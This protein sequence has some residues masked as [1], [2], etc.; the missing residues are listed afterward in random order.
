M[1]ILAD[2]L[3]SRNDIVSLLV[4]LAV[5]LGLARI[6]GEL[7]R[8]FRQ[9][10]VIGEILAGI[11]LGPSCLAHFFP[12]MFTWVF[13]DAGPTRLALEGMVTLGVLLL[14][15]VAG[16]EVDLS[17]ALRQGK[18]AMMVSFMGIVVPF[19]IGLTGAWF[20]GRYL[21]STAATPADH[22]SFALFMGIALSITALPVISKILMDLNMLRSDIGMLII[23]AAMIDDLV[24]WIGFA[25]V[26]ATLSQG[27]NA[28]VMT[29][30][31]LTLAYL[32]L[33]LTLGRLLIHRMIP[34][35]QART[36]WPGGVIGFILVVTLFAAAFTEWIGVHAIFGAFIAGVAIGDSSHLRQR[37]RDTIHQFI[38][39]FFAPIFFAT[40][41]LRVNFWQS[42]DLLTV[43]VVLAVA[44]VS[45]V[46]GCYS[47][48]PS[49][50]AWASERGWPWA[51]AWRRKRGRWKSSWPN[52]CKNAT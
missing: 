3:L 12:Q 44:L 6:L 14:L 30:I 28:D 50:R 11:L 41:G 39:H 4:S 22:W 16:L 52:C 15:L 46:G 36:S 40:I 24:G 26:L 38:T 17:T 48:Q 47:G 49:W 9:P 19:T 2:A 31:M 1:P 13:P 51:S 8:H 35:V 10:M 27:S 7:A 43:L 23:S 33:M 21:G 18:T 25:L 32:G 5:L 29:T 42:F 20:G 34:L 37:T 45:K